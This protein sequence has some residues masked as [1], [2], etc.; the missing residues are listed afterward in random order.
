MPGFKIIMND[1]C[2]EPANFAEQTNVVETARKHRYKIEVLEPLGDE[3]TGILL[4][5]YKCT[6]PNIEFDEITIHNSQ[7]EI[8]RP[9]KQHW[10]PVEFTFYEKLSGESVYHNKT[11]ELIY[12]WWSSTMMIIEKSLFNEPSVYLKQ[13]QLSMLDGVGDIVWLYNMY[14]CWPSKISPS[15]LDYSNAAI[16]EITITLRYDKAVEFSKLYKFSSP[17]AK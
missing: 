3:L 8:F 5:G 17:S 14:N 13:C 15:D 11:A 1:G 7:D 6:R 4:F 9:G 12:N 16:S 2:G 10:K